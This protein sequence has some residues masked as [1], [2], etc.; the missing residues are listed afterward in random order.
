MT[1]YTKLIERLEQQ[2]LIRSK[3]T[4]AACAKDGIDPDLFFELGKE[5]EAKQVC[6]DCPLKS[7]VLTML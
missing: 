3:Q 6:A 4:S 7:V 1:E 5:E 2:Q